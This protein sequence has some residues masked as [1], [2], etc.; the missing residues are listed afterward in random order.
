MIFEHSNMLPS[1]LHARVIRFQFNAL[2]D[3]AAS[4]IT[5]SLGLIFRGGCGFTVF[6]GA[7]SVEKLNDIEYILES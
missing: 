3:P 2:R 4:G 1:I 7:K 5:A 6:E